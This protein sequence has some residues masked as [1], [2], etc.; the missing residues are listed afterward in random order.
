[1]TEATR[2]GYLVVKCFCNATFETRAADR[3]RGWG[4]Y[5]SKSCK[6]TAQSMARNGNA[7]RQATLVQQTQEPE[8]QKP[9]MMEPIE[10]WMIFKMFGVDMPGKSC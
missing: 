9:L 8:T 1:M 4:I 3:K 6:A 7:P 10:D 5:C 2:H